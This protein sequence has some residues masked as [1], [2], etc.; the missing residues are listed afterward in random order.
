MWKGSKY[1][2]PWHHQWW[3]CSSEGEIPLL[4]VGLWQVVLPKDVK[5]R[6]W[7]VVIHLHKNYLQDCPLKGTRS[8]M[9]A[10]YVCDGSWRSDFRA[11][12][13]LA[14]KQVQA[15]WLMAASGS[16]NSPFWCNVFFYRAFNEREMTCIWRTRSVWLKHCVVSSSLSSTLIAVRLLSN[17]LLE[18]WSSLVKL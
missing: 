15:C 13:S 7:R 2:L 5:R 14:A 10:P 12:N 17:I 6:F 4:S 16:W 8:K 1:H 9:P 11:T 3:H 18:K